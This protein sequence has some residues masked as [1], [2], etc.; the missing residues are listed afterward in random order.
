LAPG[1]QR[2]RG[3]PPPQFS[4]LEIASRVP[5]SKGYRGNCRSASCGFRGGGVRHSPRKMGRDP[6]GSGHFKP[7]GGRDRGRVARLDQHPNRSSLPEGLLGSRHGGFSAQ[8]SRQNTEAGAART[9]PV[10]TGQEKMILSR[11]A[12]SVKKAEIGDLLAVGV[13]LERRFPGCIRRIN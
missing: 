11:F 6:L 7:L 4:A 1:V 5:L 8:L 9:V 12:S 2:F 13:G 10:F 3:R